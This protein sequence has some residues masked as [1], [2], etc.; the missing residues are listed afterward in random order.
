MR[1]EPHRM[2]AR[3]G[4]PKSRDSGMNES[5]GWNA[6]ALSV[7]PLGKRT[8]GNAKGGRHRKQI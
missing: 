1:E 4:S 5:E 2:L 8:C 6:G 7:L 3:H